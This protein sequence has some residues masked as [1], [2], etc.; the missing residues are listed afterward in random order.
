MND[1]KQELTNLSQKLG[2][3]NRGAENT[4]IEKKSE[5]ASNYN[6]S[7]NSLTNAAYELLDEENWRRILGD[8]INGGER[9]IRTLDTDKPYTSLAGKR[10]RPLGHLSIL[11]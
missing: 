9:G 5:S 10:L 11:I 2:L 8:D 3:E 1:S 6:Q 7:R 4:K